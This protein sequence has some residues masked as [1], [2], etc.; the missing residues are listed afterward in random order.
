MKEV[1]RSTFSDGLPIRPAKIEPMSNWKVKE[2]IGGLFFGVI[3]AG[4]FLVLK[5]AWFSSWQ[6]DENTW[7]NFGYTVLICGACGFFFGDKIFKIMRKI[8]GWFRHIDDRK[9]GRDEDKNPS[10]TG[11]EAFVFSPAGFVIGMI[12]G[13]CVSIYF[14]AVNPWQFSGSSFWTYLIIIATGGILGGVFGIKVFKF[15]I[16]FCG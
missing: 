13:V 2:R 10:N 14:T 5:V 7:K 3:L 9:N 16:Y 11:D 4:I 15:L 6:I 1:S 12:L 8:F